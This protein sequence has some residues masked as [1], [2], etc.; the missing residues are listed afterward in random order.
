MRVLAASC[1]SWAR[2]N[3]IAGSAR[4]GNTWVRGRSPVIDPS[5]SRGPHGT[6]A[7]WDVST[8]SA[9]NVTSFARSPGCGTRHR[10]RARLI[11]LSVPGKCSKHIAMLG[12]AESV[13]GHIHVVEGRGS[14]CGCAHPSVVF[15]APLAPMMTSS[16]RRGFVRVRHRRWTC[17]GRGPRRS[18]L[19]SATSRRCFGS[20]G[21]STQHFYRLAP[22]IIREAGRQHGFFASGRRQRRPRAPLRWKFA[23]PRFRIQPVPAPKE[24]THGR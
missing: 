1:G 19:A 16:S 14:G 11:R 8:C 2:L 12:L 9:T 7:C 15:A 18:F 20:R 21:V 13:A 3:A 17:C 23:G 22:A 10:F 4:M 24:T 6:R 5:P